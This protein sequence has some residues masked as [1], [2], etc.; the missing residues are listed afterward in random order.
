M[1]WIRLSNGTRSFCVDAGGR[2]DLHILPEGE[3][4]PGENPGRQHGTTRN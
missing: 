3:L 2:L 1:K 4:P